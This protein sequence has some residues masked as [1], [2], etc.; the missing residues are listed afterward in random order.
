MYLWLVIISIRTET[1]KTKFYKYENKICTIFFCKSYNLNNSDYIIDN[2]T[3]INNSSY[4]FNNIIVL[5]IYSFINQFYLYFFFFI[6]LWY[7]LE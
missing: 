5:C 3:S 2:I 1:A 6:S 7:D 4:I